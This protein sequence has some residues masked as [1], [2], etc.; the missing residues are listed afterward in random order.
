MLD[1]NQQLRY[2]NIA[3]EHLLDISSQKALGLSLKELFINPDDDLL[4]IEGV[5]SGRGNFTKRAAELTL[6]NGK[7]IIVD[8]SVNIVGD[9]SDDQLLL[10]LRSLEHSHRINREESITAA[11]ATTRELVRGLAHEIKNPLTPIQLSAQRLR[12]RYLADFEDDDSVFDEC[13]TM[14]IKQV[15]EKTRSKTSV[16]DLLRD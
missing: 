1:T 6:L 3:A 5:L 14:I 13:T 12:R 8:Y 4:E 15:D 7:V 9:N 2:L 10:E 16:N 11:H